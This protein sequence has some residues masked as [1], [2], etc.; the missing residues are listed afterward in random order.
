M[1]SFELAK[2][3]CATCDAISAPSR[4]DPT[5]PSCRGDQFNVEIE[6]S[7]SGIDGE[8]IIETLWKGTT[9]GGGAVGTF[10]D[11]AMD[12]EQGSGD[13][14]RTYSLLSCKSVSGQEILSFLGVSVEER[15]HMYVIW[16]RREIETQLTDG[17]RICERCKVLFKVYDND[18]NTGGFCSR[19][20]HIAF[21]KSWNM[22]R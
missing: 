17:H 22:S 16:K 11:V 10:L 3:A 6:R 18:W 8:N 4:F 9:M 5:C 20:C 14:Y 15:R 2:I 19:T 1:K 13:I 21:I 7:A 12:D